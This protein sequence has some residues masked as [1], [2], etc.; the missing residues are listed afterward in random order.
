MSLLKHIYQAQWREGKIETNLWAP[1][2]G[3]LKTTGG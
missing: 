3:Y 1:F 2:S